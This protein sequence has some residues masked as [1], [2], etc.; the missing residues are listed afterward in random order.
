[1][2]ENS[3]ENNI[4]SKEQL[5]SIF[6]EETEVINSLLSQDEKLKKEY[7]IN[8]ND[9][10][11]FNFLLLYLRKSEKLYDIKVIL[12][13]KKLSRHL[14]FLKNFEN[15]NQKVNLILSKLFL[16]FIFN[17][18]QICKIFGYKKENFSKKI[19]LL[20]K[21]H[22]L[23]NLIDKENIMNII[24]LK[25]YFC[26]YEEKFTS[27]IREF[28]KEIIYNKKIANLSPLE[29]TINFLLSFTEEEM[30]KK[31]LIDFNYII[32]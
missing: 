15:N 12:R 18:S 22:Y 8:P 5:F 32:N 4:I 31:K 21:A 7:L 27:H 13:H 6:N 14:M 29:E 24:R 1:M 3:F 28:N 19:F 26:F 25:L 20:I 23:H 16:I 17:S 11:I 2:S 10:K 30:P 9:K